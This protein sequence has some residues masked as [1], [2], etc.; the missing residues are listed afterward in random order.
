MLAANAQAANTLRDIQFASEASGVVQITLQLDGPASDASVFTTDDPPRIA[1]DLP[2][3]MNAVEKRRIAVGAGAASAITALEANGRTRVVVDLFRAAS[4]ESRVEANRFILTVGAGTGGG[5][6]AASVAAAASQNDPSKQTKDTASVRN[7]DFRRGENGG[8]R[9]IVT[10]SNENQPADYN[11]SGE[12][13]TVS[14]SGAMVPE[15]LAQRLDVRDFATPVDMVELNQGNAGARLRIAASGKYQASAYQSGAEYVV[16]LSPVAEAAEGDALGVLEDV[17]TYEGTPVT[18]NFQNIP[19]R[20]V[21]QLVAEES[22]LNVVAADTV[23]GNVT[24]RLINVPWDQAL[25]IVLRAK[26]L[27]QRR[28]GNVVWVAP[29]AELAAYEQAKADARLALEQRA[30]LITEYIAV[31]YGNAEDLAKL[32][33]EESKRAT[34]G[35]GAAQGSSSGFLSPRGSISF[36][37]RTNTL[38]VNDSEE[39]VR[40]VKA[41]VALLDRAVDQVLIEARI[42]VASESFARE[43][44]ARFGISGG[45]EDSRGNILTSSGSVLG[46]DAMANAALANRFNGRGSGLPVAAPGG[47]GSGIVTPALGD[48][49]NVNLPVS[50]PTGSIGFALLGADYLLDLELSAL[51]AE[52][53]GEVVSSPRVITANQREAFVK[54]GDEIG[55][56]VR[57]GSGADATTTIQFKEVVLELRVTPTITQD[58]RVALNVLVKKDEV[59]G[60]SP[61]GEPNIT[62]RE[63][64]TA[65]L[66]DNSQTVVVGGVYEFESREDLSKVPFLGDVPVLGNLFR[67]KSRRSNKAELLIFITPKILDTQKSGAQ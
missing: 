26:G 32:L 1:I 29:Q 18:F 24:L 60:F 40:E 31:N 13:I 46:T 19:V 2:E 20:T 25:D 66:M 41:V 61:T 23:T 53:R 67:N 55:F 37:R 12:G 33:T 58:G 38:L 47:V 4:F 54:Q 28:E 43:L 42:V 51:E 11:D 27:D 17:K 63:I 8:G 56:P 5:G 22:G 3:T 64:S 36:D 16:E 62:K 59:A 48:R 14:F 65:V 52:G 30:E 44:G 21:L 6:L 34:G 49:L 7:I 45:Y 35:G 9:V 15:A 57:Q 39:K 50:A 10:L